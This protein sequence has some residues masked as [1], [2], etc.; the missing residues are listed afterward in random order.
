MSIAEKLYL[1]MVLSLFFGFMALMVTLTWLDAKE[2][3]AKRA[4][5]QRKATAGKT[6][7]AIQ[8]KAAAQH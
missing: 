1:G 6:A 3:R 2:S 5:P 8:G 4:V 7:P